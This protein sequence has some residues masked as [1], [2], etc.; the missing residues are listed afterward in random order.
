MKRGRAKKKFQELQETFSSERGMMPD[1]VAE[2]M[3]LA[4]E[5]VRQGGE[6]R[7]CVTKNVLFAVMS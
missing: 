7:A 2:E 4:N 3:E 1:N 6:K 5:D